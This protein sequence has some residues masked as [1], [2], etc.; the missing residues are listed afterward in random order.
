MRL[1]ITKDISMKEL[2][3]NK[4]DGGGVDIP[5]P[6]EI[7]KYLNKYVIKQNEV[8]KALAV[9]A[10]KHLHINKYN[11]QITNYEEFSKEA[12]DLYTFLLKEK[13]EKVHKIKH[14]NL[15]IIGPSGSGKTLSIT[16]LAEFLKVPHY[17]A[18]A[19]SLT[20]IGYVGDSVDSILAG[21]FLA[22][23]KDINK[24]QQGIIFID[25]VDKLILKNT[26]GHRDIGGLSVQNG[27]LRL[28]EGG[29]V[30]IDAKENG[31]TTNPA[32]NFKIRFDT[33]Q[34]L[35]ILGGAF[36]DVRTKLD[37]EVN[38]DKIGFKSK[39]VSKKTK[40]KV[41]IT[42]LIEGGMTPEFIGRV[43]SI[44]E[45]EALTKIDLKNILLKPEDSLMKQYKIIF[46]LMKIDWEQIDKDKLINKV[47]DGAIKL[48]TGARGL[49]TL[50][51][52]ELRNYMYKAG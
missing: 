1:T 46:E 28:L 10:V 38:K 41:G 44:V 31:L 48:E 16:K 26:S 5:T 33:S 29:I 24:A 3:L 22:A 20:S 4:S 2:I 27:L 37:E 12:P 43:G 51:E 19:T 47:V 35:F 14:Q 49:N 34:V 30:N 25:E 15:M 36:T 23:D 6:S 9:T 21:L 17:I 40:V 52:Q 7:M 42:D 11:S 8:K 45:T 50:M 13:V 18:D 32:S 39:K